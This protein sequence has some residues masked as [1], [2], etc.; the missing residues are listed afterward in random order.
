MVSAI[1][2]RPGT[3]PIDKASAPPSRSASQLRRAWVTSR[4]R[5]VRKNF[6]AKTEGLSASK[7]PS[8]LKIVP[9]CLLSSVCLSQSAHI[10]YCGCWSEL[11]CWAHLPLVPQ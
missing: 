5:L 4:V 10:T 8:P 9:Y 11:A 1:D 3:R 2:S 6:E 7:T